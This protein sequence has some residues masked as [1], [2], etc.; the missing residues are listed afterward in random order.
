MLPFHFNFFGRVEAFWFCIVS[1]EIFAFIAVHL[2]S[3]SKRES[4]SIPMSRSL[5]P[6]FS[7]KSFTVSGL[8]FK[9]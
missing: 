7:S 8:I 2:V 3:Y 1:L 9:F 6:I 4:L 5:F